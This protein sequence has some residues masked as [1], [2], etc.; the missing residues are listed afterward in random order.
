MLTRS[1]ATICNELRGCAG[2]L[3]I[4]GNIFA[5]FDNESYPRLLHVR[6]YV[7]ATIIIYW[8]NIVLGLHS[9]ARSL[10]SYQ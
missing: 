10:C 7:D 5:L 1:G 8:F 4:R 2:G 6:I 3:P 9:S